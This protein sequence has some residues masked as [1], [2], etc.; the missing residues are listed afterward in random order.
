MSDI[1][2]RRTTKTQFEPTIAV[3]SRW[4]GHADGRL[5]TSRFDR[6]DGNVYEDGM[7]DVV[8]RLDGGIALTCGRGT[9]AARPRWIAVGGGDEPQETAVVMPAIPLG[10]TYSVASLAGALA[11]TVSN[12]QGQWQIGL[13]MDRM[14]GVWPLEHVN[15]MEEHGWAFTRDVYVRDTTSTTTELVDDPAAVAERLVRPLLVAL[16]VDRFH[17]PYRPVVSR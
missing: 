13:Y 9:D 2:G 3:A 16:G 7:V 8:I 10:L 5:M 14:R 1:A 6:S 15:S 11:D 4:R 12:Y 17:I